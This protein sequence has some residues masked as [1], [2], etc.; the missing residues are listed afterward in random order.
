MDQLS[1]VSVK[2]QE[3][4]VVKGK[5]GGGELNYFPPLFFIPFSKDLIPAIAFPPGSRTKTRQAKC[6]RGRAHGVRRGPRRAP[7]TPSRCSRS[8]GVLPGA[9]PPSS[10]SRNNSA[11]P[12]AGSSSSSPRGSSMP[13]RPSRRLRC[14]SSG[15]RRATSASSCRTSGGLCFIVVS[16]PTLSHFSHAVLPS[17]TIPLICILAVKAV[18]TVV[19]IA[20][21]SSRCVEFCRGFSTSSTSSFYFSFFFSFFLPPNP[22]S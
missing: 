10:C 20:P 6:A 17:L 19:F 8:V 2:L 5:G 15:K 14:A 7:W 9:A 16:P 11:R 4:A 21:A 13:A 22:F 12:R 1:K 18:L 3:R